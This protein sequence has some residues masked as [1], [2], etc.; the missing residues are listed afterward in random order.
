MST[1]SITFE[2]DPSRMVSVL[3]RVDEGVQSETGAFRAGINRAGETYLG[4]MRQRFNANSVGGGGWA[5]LKPATILLK[6]RRGAG[7]LILVF[8]GKLR[9]S[10]SRGNPGNIFQVIT[11]GVRVGTSDRTARFHQ[12]GTRFMPAR[13]ILVPPDAAT[14]QQM[15]TDL[16]TG[17]I[18][19]IKQAAA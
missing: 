16:T 3:H 19:Q 17:T 2:M 12:G 18:E 5:P 14:R 6:R 10:L 1:L 15:A 9:Q 11:N 13:P 4:A 8:S 7:S